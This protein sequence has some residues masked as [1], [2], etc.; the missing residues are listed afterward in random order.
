MITK[1]KDFSGIVNIGGKYFKLNFDDS[2]IPFEVNL[3]VKNGLYD[4]LSVIIPDSK[5][6]DHKEFFMNP[7]IEQ[8]I[9]DTLKKENFIQETGKNSIAG[10]K[11]TKSY[12]VNL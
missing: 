7:D 12:I 5:T 8:N 11:P 4:N 9:I 6:L 1:F 3:Y 2:K 10:D